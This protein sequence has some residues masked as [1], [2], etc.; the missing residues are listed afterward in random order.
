MIILFV[1]FLVFYS[2]RKG[3]FCASIFVDVLTGFLKE[4]HMAK[5]E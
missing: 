5:P 2:N 4:G 1:H 3:I